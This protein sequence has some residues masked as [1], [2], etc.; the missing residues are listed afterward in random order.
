MKRTI[1][2]AVAILLWVAWAPPAA[3]KPPLWDTIKSSGRFKIVK[4]SNN[5]AVSDAETGLLWTISPGAGS[6]GGCTSPVSWFSAIYCCLTTNAGGRFG[7]RLPS[8][9]ELATLVDGSLASPALPAGNPFTG[10]SGSYWTA[11]TITADTANALV[12]NFPAYFNF[13]VAKTSTESFWCVRAPGGFD[14]GN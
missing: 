8:A 11:T 9:Q 14:L 4:G 6:T 7:W 12:A 2:A 1:Y 5:Q 13:Q 10:V 3:A